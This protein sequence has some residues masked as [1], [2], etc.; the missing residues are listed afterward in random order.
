M[1]IDNIIGGSGYAVSQGPHDKGHL[2]H[3][4]RDEGV[5][6]PTVLE[7]NSF[8]ALERIEKPA[9]VTSEGL[10]VLFVN[11][12]RNPRA[13]LREDT[14]TRTCI[15]LPRSIPCLLVSLPGKVRKPHDHVDPDIAFFTREIIQSML[16]AGI[17]KQFHRHSLRAQKMI[18]LERLGPGH[19]YVGGANH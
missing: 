6:G 11:F 1:I 17:G 10:L 14:F 12:E 5:V 2:S 7:I 4:R 9:F 16:H 15:Y 8:F 19:P 18:I 3:R 13:L